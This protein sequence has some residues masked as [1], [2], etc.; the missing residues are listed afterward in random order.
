M[1]KF[2]LI[3]GALVA[4][5]VPSTAMAGQPADPGYF[6]TYRADALHGWINDWYSNAPGASEVGKWFANIGGDNGT[7]NQEWRAD[8]PQSMPQ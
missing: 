6:G 8:N 3:A 4:L 7:V 5:T 1:R 2:F